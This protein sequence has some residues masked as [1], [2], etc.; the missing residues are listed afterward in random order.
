MM[1]S[2][3]LLRDLIMN[4]DALERKLKR[5]RDEVCLHGRK[6]VSCHEIGEFEECAEFEEV[7]DEA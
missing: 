6:F 3:P 7:Y 4:D 2:N 1:K 5:D